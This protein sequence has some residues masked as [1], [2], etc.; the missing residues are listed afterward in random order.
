VLRLTANSIIPL[1]FNVPRKTYSIFHD[2]LYPDTKWTVPGMTADEYLAGANMTAPKYPV[3]PS[4]R[5]SRP[6]GSSGTAA[7]ATASTSSPAAVGSS[8]SPAPASSPSPAGGNSGDRLVSKTTSMSLHSSSPSPQPEES[9][10]AK[11]EVIAV[12]DVKY[13]F[14]GVR[15]SSYRYISGKPLH[16]STNYDHL[17]D[18]SLKMTGECDALAVSSEFLAVPLNKPGG[19][20]GI[21]PI[22]NMGRQPAKLPALVNTG[23][24]L[25]F[26][27][28]PFDPRMVAAAC[29]DS[30][31]RVWKIPEG[32]LTEDTTEVFLKLSG[33]RH[34]VNLVRFHPTAR[35]I[36]VSSST[37]LSEPTIKYWD[38]TTGK[39]IL[40]LTGFQDQV[41]SFDHNSDGSLLAVVSKDKM[42]RIFDTR[43]KK[44]IRV[45][46]F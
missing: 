11:A 30:Y 24:V 43:A 14:T 38:L 8:S 40:T 15:Q 18:L 25:D 36:L 35:N 13:K 41:F 2:D 5:P 39:E 10:P 33:H 7:P 16:P 46:A 17:K 29:D 19:Q 27:F 21:I 6:P 37:E 3:D 4:K 45:R 12:K 42:L 28:N 23:E 26:V 44:L 1:R 31:I 22:K 20:I 32:G 34:R 9:E